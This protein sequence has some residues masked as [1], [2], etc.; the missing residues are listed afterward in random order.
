MHKAYCTKC[1][2]NWAA[3]KETEI[4]DNFETH[5]VCPK[6]L[7]SMDLV[8]AIE[9]KALTPYNPFEPIPNIFQ[10]GNF[11]PVPQ[12]SKEAIEAYKK[13]DAR[14]RNSTINY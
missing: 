7:S 4:D 10:S 9:G 3:L 12:N 5:H 2:T 11:P 14:K 13:I 1:R 8:E 6:C